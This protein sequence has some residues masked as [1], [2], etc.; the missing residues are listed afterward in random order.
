MV[1]AVTVVDFEHPRSWAVSLFEIFDTL[2]THPSSR[3][4][5]L[6]SLISPETENPRYV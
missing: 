1:L 2:L 3:V 4:Q 6:G 5:S